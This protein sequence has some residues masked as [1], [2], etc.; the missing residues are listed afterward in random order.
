LQA[1]AARLV[2]QAG[3]RATHIELLDFDIPMYNADL[4][5][6]GTP[7]AVIRLK[8]WMHSHVGWIIASPEYNGF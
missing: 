6:A 7:V 1:Q 3:A 4:E 8:E 2:E 5:Q